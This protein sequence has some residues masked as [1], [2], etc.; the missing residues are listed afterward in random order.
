MHPLPFIVQ[1]LLKVCLAS[2]RHFF[3]LQEKVQTDLGM[4]L[5]VS[6]GPSFDFEPWSGSDVWWQTILCLEK[7]GWFLQH[8][9]AC[10]A[11]SFVMAETNQQLHGLWF[12][13][14]WTWRFTSVPLGSLK[15]VRKLLL[16]FLLTEL[17]QERMHIFVLC[18]SADN[19]ALR[20]IC[21][22]TDMLISRTV[23]TCLWANIYDVMTWGKIQT[24]KIKKEERAGIKSN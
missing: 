17:L 10:R 22:Q 16:C 18:P 14:K 3:W 6:L 24:G 15:L 12:I 5:Y 8:Q 1:L 23:K 2:K 21:F 11:K 19:T 9:G 4:W 7:V 13:W 20:I